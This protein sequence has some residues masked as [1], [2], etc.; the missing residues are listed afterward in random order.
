M[1]QFRVCTLSGL[2]EVPE[3]SKANVVE[4]GDGAFCRLHDRHTVYDIQV[5]IESQE[6]G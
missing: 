4:V 3:F 2:Q 5:L 6:C 1:Q